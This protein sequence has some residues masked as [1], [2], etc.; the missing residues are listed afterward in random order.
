MA[1]VLPTVLITGAT[2]LLG[3]AIAQAFRDTGRFRVT[4]VSFSRGGPD[5][6][7]CD[8]RNSDAIAKLLVDTAPALVVHAAAERK[9]DVC[10]SDESGSELLNVD[11]VWHLSRGASRAGAAFVHISTDYIFDGKAP[12]YTETSPAAPLNAYGR[13]KLRGE[14][15]ALAGHAHAFVLRV[16]VLYGPSPDVSESAITVFAKSV[17]ESH[18][19]RTLD[20]WQV[21]VPTLTTDI[22]ETLVRIA[23]GLL[24]AGGGERLGGVWHYSSGDKFTR[25]SVAQR[26]AGLL[27]LPAGHIKGDASPPAGAPRPHDALLDCSK[28]VAAGLA[29]PPTPFDE[30]MARVL[31][32]FTVDPVAHTI[33]PK[34]HAAGAP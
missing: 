30:G 29:A 17:V 12:P 21:R 26:I 23:G 11:C 22:A 14:Y 9:P 8:L 31:A 4:G 13:Q 27:G 7:R 28:L 32:G 19:P 25:F 34:A 6:V 1:A 20:D 16:P 24:A 18:V 5:S 10:E 15:A 2:G 33:L 3:R